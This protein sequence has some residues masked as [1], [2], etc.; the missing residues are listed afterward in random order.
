MVDHP[1]SK[2]ILPDRTYQGLVRSELKK[3]VEAA[4]FTGHRLGEVEIVIAEIT[5]NLVKH[6]HKGGEILA[7][8]ITTPFP[9][10]EFIS[11]DKG[12]GMSRPMKMMEDGLSTSNTLGQG[13]GAIRRLSSAFDLYSLPAWGTILFSRLYRDKSQE[14]PKHLLEL[15]A[16]SVCKKNEIVCGDLWTSAI[17]GKKYRLMMIDGLGHGHSAHTAAREAVTTFHD[18]PKVTPVEQ[19]RAL[20]DRLKK[21]RGGVVTVAYIDEINQQLKYSGV[22]NITMKVVS[23]ARAHGCLSYNGIVGHIMPAVL[24]DHVLQIDRRADILILHS[25][26]LSGRWDLQKYPGILQHHGM[27]IGAALY[28]DFDRGNDDSTILVA[29][30]SK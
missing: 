20:H 3:M 17:H 15:S 11:I 5:S 6:A 24:N 21:T 2:F 10:V 19:L 16:I 4:G 13:L 9:G 25:D 14:S 1:H 7:R 29:K 12:P 22:G 23:P 27:I 30:F 18:S 26:G 8:P 28:K